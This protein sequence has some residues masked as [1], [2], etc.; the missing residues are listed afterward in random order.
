MTKAVSFISV[1]FILVLCFEIAFYSRVEWKCNISIPKCKKK[2]KKDSRSPCKCS[3]ATPL[4]KLSLSFFYYLK[5]TSKCSFFTLNRNSFPQVFQL[6]H[7]STACRVRSV[8]SL[9]SWGWREVQSCELS[10]GPE[11]L[12]SPSD[13]VQ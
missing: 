11:L 1:G 9:T 8:L 2:H 3:C 13:E 5:K 7:Q 6:E 12:H 10:P 4:T